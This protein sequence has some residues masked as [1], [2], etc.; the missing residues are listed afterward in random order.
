MRIV[1]YIILIHYRT[2]YPKNRMSHT[3]TSTL[4]STTLYP[5]HSIVCCCH[6]LSSSNLHRNFYHQIYHSSSSPSISSCPS[7]YA[8]LSSTSHPHP[9]Q[10]QKRRSSPAFTYW[11]SC[12]YIDIPPQDAYPKSKD[13]PN[14]T[15]KYRPAT[16]LIS[17]KDLMII[18]NFIRHHIDPNLPLLDFPTTSRTII[19]YLHV[20]FQTIRT[21]SMT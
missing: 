2:S 9:S 12:P 19:R 18:N 5:P 13:N 17:A 16:I 3:S 20:G 8:H 1:N 15:H 11:P 10:P 4:T 7:M 6:H 14:S 21:K